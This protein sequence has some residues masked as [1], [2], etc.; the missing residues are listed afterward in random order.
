LVHHT[1]TEDMRV[2][3][4]ATSPE[5]ATATCDFLLR[6]FA[7]FAGGYFPRSN[8]PL[9]NHVRMVGNRQL[10]VS[11]EALAEIVTEIMF[12]GLFNC[13]L[14]EQHCNALRRASPSLQLRLHDCSAS[15]SIGAGDAFVE[16]LQ[17]IRSPMVVKW[18][19]AGSGVLARALSGESQV[20]ELSIDPSDH[21]TDS[22]PIIRALELNTG[23]VQLSVDMWPWEDYDQVLTAVCH[24][25]RL[26][27]TITTLEFE[28]WD[29]DVVSLSEESQTIWLQ[30]IDGLLQTNMVLTKIKLPCNLPRLCNL[31]ETR[32]Y[33]EEITPRLEMNRFREHFLAL[34]DSP[35]NGELRAKLLCRAL[36]LPSVRNSHNLVFTLL[37]DNQELLACDLE[38]ENE[39]QDLT[40]A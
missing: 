30:A 21:R 22:Y 18:N 29:A 6:L 15:A 4:Y 5:Q 35:D 24:S 27:T 34:K 19:N 28:L 36:A 33:Q 3:V 9:R 25:L 16:C 32:L 23:L 8:H 40:H 11:G 10:C 1:I 38:D 20:K 2:D 7:F 17:S 26:H 37:S 39:I 13:D 31:A 14:D 12:L